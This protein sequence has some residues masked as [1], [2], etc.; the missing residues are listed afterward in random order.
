MIWILISYI[1]SDC[2]W[3]WKNSFVARKYSANCLNL[4]KA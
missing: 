2:E 4:D 1:V 3:F